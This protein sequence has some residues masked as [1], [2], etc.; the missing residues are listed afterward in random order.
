VM[1]YE[2]KGL[3]IG[4]GVEKATAL[5]VRAIISAETEVESVGKLGTLYLGPEDVMLAVEVRFRRDGSVADTRHTIGHMTN[6][7]RAK[8]PRIRHVFLDA[9]SIGE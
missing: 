7:I 4:E 5:G 8:Y 9:S 6:A 3:L 1:V 2:S